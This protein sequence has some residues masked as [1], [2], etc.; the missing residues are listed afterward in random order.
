LEDLNYRVDLLGSYIERRGVTLSPG[1]IQ[2]KV[3]LINPECRYLCFF[4]VDKFS[5]QFVEVEII[6]LQHNEIPIL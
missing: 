1:F 4:F 5:P 6:S 2:Q 3:F